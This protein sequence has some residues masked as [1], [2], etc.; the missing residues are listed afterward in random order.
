MPNNLQDADDLWALRASNT[1]GVSSTALARALRFDASYFAGETG[2]VHTI[3][4]ASEGGGTVLGSVARVVMLSGFSIDWIRAKNWDFGKG[5]YPASAITELS[6][7]PSLYISP[8]A[9]PNVVNFEVKRGWIAITR[10][11]TVGNVGLIYKNLD[12]NFLSND[13]IRVIPHEKDELG[14]LYAFLSS[15]Y[16][17]VLLQDFTYGSVIGHIKT[18]QVESIPVPAVSEE[19]H[20]KLGDLT[21]CVLELRDEAT[22]LLRE[23]QKRVVSVN[24]LPELGPRDNT[25]EDFELCHE[26][27]AIVVSS[28][29]IADNFG[30]GSEFRLDAR[31]Y[32]PTVQLSVRNLKACRAEL[33]TVGE[34]SERIILASR[35]KRNYVKP[36]YGTPFLSGK[37]IVQIRP[38]LKYLAHSQVREMPELIIER[39]WTL[40]TCSGT[41]GRT[42]FVWHNYE[43]YAASQHILRVAPDSK[44]IDPGYLYAFLS[45]PYGYEQIVRHRHGSVIDEI[46]DRQT[47]KVLVPRP[48]RDEQE[49][50][51]DLVRSAYEKRAEAIRSEDEAQEILMNELTKA[52]TLE[53]D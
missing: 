6:P 52:S 27:E 35:F 44:M 10:S 38:D 45:S 29:T 51:G 34:L 43:N 17:R 53:G 24:G 2:R 23:A 14:L 46:T 11:G 4:S 49:Q 36:Q 41:I 16:G 40:I 3:I 7:D 42:C 15:D 37:N 32:N 28:G 31:Y 19:A 8:E 25:R 21:V 39:G 9:D 20:K 12:G 22:E 30:N 1:V 13:A 18:F 26:I 5:M 50:I 33:R 48:T 47:E